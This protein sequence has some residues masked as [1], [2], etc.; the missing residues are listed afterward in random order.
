MYQNAY[1]VTLAQTKLFLFYYHV[2]HIYLA[3]PQSILAC[4]SSFKKRVHQ[5]VFVCVQVNT[6]HHTLCVHVILVSHGN[7]ITLKVKASN[8]KYS[9]L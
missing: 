2:M 4:F 7:K 6:T 5:Q 8:I 1:Q 9:V 3:T